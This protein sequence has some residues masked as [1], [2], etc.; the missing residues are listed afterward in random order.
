M[1]AFGVVVAG[2]VLGRSLLIPL[3]V[4]ILLW[5]LL[6]AMIEGFARLSSWI[7]QA[8]AIA[9]YDS[10]DRNR[11]TWILSCRVHPLGAG[12][13]DRRCVAALCSPL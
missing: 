9:R 4:A 12:R 13:C 6:E 7:L 10:W 1:I 8:A 3:A 5:N 11:R 2:L